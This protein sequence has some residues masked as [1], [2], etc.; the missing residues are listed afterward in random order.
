MLQIGDFGMARDLMDDTYYKSSGGKVPVKWTAPE[1]LLYRKY[2]TASDVWSYGMV[3]FE[4]WSV[5]KTPFRL[6]NNSD[7]IARLQSC[8]CLPPPPG[9]PREVYKLMVEC[10]YVAEQTPYCCCRCSASTISKVFVHMCGGSVIRRAHC[11]RNRG[12][13]FSLNYTPH[14]LQPLAI[15]DLPTIHSPSVEWMF[16]PMVL[17]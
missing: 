12:S 4:I 9:C 1:A 8:Q 11:W 14:A 7:M 3:M 2:S 15:F 10:W 5:G 16:T 6:L 13:Q 17:G